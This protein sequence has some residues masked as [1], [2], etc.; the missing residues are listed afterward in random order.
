MTNT[1]IALPRRAR[2]RHMQA[3]TKAEV[4]AFL[5][6]QSPRLGVHD[7]TVEN[8][9]TLRARYPGEL[10]AKLMAGCVLWEASPST[11]A[12]RE[13]VGIVFCP[14]PWGSPGTLLYAEVFERSPPGDR[15]LWVLARSGEPIIDEAGWVSLKT[16]LA[17]VPE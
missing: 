7:V 11:T 17:S 15:G 10:T 3:A 13:E 5:R 12:S 14:P 8:L 2:R 4:L 16:R 9:A 1:D 6:L